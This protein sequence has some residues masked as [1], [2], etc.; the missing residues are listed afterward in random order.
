M[1]NSST[2]HWNSKM[3]KNDTCSQQMAVVIIVRDWNIAV[4]YE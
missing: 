1:S 3:K 4:K 2:C